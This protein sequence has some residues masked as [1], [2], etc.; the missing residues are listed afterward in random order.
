M[1]DI[2]FRR[3]HRADLEQIVALI[4]DDSVNGHRE[5]PGEPLVDGYVEAFAAIDADPN[6]VLIVGES[7][8]RPVATAQITFVPNLTQQGGMRAIVEGVRVASDMRSR[9]FGEKLMEYMT[10]LA[11]E[12]GC[13]YVQL[14]TS[15]ARIDAHRFYHRIGFAHSHLGFKRD[16]K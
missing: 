4:A 2:A 8:G 14:T 11:R 5:R 7:A 6:N 15:K 16:L 9:G 10:E 13:A 12:R 1:P 3:A